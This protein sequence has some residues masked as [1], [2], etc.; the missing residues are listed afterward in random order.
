MFGSSHPYSG[1]T[2]GVAS[3]RSSRI[4][5]TEEGKRPTDDGNGSRTNP[6][7][8]PA[9]MPVQFE[10]RIIDRQ[11]RLA[12]RPWRI[13]IKTKGRILLL[14]AADVVA[15]EARGNYVLLQLE[16]ESYLVRDS[17][18]TLEDKL[19]RCGFVRIHR[20]VLINGRHAREIRP[21]PTGEYLI[22]TEGGREYVTSRTYRRNLNALAQ[23]W[24]GACALPERECDRPQQTDFHP[25]I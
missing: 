17:I 22:R 15:I 11:E 25:E 13:A 23:V 3:P 12:R 6:I 14:N 24:I 16:T 21:Q 2:E 1:Q 9:R 8:F 5:A 18:S 20:S 19:Q 4:P 10:K 7:P